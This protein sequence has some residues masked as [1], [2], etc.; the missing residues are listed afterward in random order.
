LTRERRQRQAARVIVIDDQDRVLLLRGGDPAR[1]EAGTWWFTPGGG[2]EAGETTEAAARRELF[3][4]TGLVRDDLGPVVYSDAV[5][6]RFDGLIYEQSQSF[7]RLRT[8][9]FE[10]DTSRWDPLEV[11]SITEH[12]WWT[13]EELR[14]TNDQVY[15]TSLLDLLDG[16]DLA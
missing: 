5:E 15:P 7:F 12:R 14:A 6:F 11:A 13:R 10:I 8:A 4:E 1:P 16:F 9:G 3:E 2:I